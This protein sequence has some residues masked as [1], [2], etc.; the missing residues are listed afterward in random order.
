LA[1]APITPCALLAL[2]GQGEWWLAPAILYAYYFGLI[3]VPAYFV[4]K[5]LGW[6]R[7]WQVVSGG[8]GLGA[9]VAL[10][11][12]SGSAA[13]RFAALGALTAAV[14]WVLACTPVRSRRFP[15]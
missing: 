4:F 11:F 6:L 1:L 9:A 14:F 12:F 7:L 10:V 8:A 13:P 15:R 3:G 2:E 5:T